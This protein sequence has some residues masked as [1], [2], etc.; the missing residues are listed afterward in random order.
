MEPLTIFGLAVNIIQ[1]VDFS[2]RLLREAHELHHSST[3]QTAEHVELHQISASLSQM[4]DSLAYTQSDQRSRLTLVEH[5]ITENAASAKAVAEDL[6]AVVKKLKIND[7]SK[8]RR[9][10][11]FRQALA[12]LWNKDEIDRLQK[13]LGELRN[14][15]SANMI[16]HISLVQRE[17]VKDLN[18]LRRECEQINVTRTDTVKLLLQ[19]I[20]KLSLN[21][22]TKKHLEELEKVLGEI[23]NSQLKIGRE[24]MILRSLR[25]KEMLDRYHAI[26]KAHTNTFS[27]IFKPSSFPACDARSKITFKEWLSS[28]TGIYWISGK[29]GSGKSTLMKYLY[30]CEET[31]EYLRNWA[32]GGKLIVSASYFWI[33]G[34]EMQRSLRGLLQHLLFQV[35]RVCPD[36]I[37]LLFSERFSEDR[38]EDWSDDLSEDDEDESG[39]TDVWDISRLQTTFERLNRTTDNTKICFFIDGLDEYS[40]DGGDHLDLINLIRRL[41]EVSNVKLC[42]SSRRWTCFED[43]FGQDSRHKLYLEDLT[44]DDILRFTRDK[45]NEAP[46]YDRLM[47]GQ[48]SD[49]DLVSE[50][51]RK[52]QGVFLWVHLVVK[53]LRRILIDGE[54]DISILQ[55]KLEEIPADLEEFFDKLL[56]SVDEAYKKQM[57]LLFKVAL[58]APEPLSLAIYWFLDS[59]KPYQTCQYPLGVNIL[60]IEDR[61][62]R[63]LNGRYKGLLEAYGAPGGK[64]VA[65][66]HR[67]VH[68]YLKKPDIQSRFLQTNLNI[69]WEACRAI[70]AAE[71]FSAEQTPF[72]KATFGPQVS[73]DS[74]RWLLD[75]GADPNRSTSEGTIFW[76]FLN[77]YGKDSTRDDEFLSMLLISGADFHK[78]AITSPAARNL[79]AI[80]NFCEPLSRLIAEDWKNYLTKLLHLWTKLLKEG[81]GIDPNHTTSSHSSWEVW[82]WYI[83]QW[84]TDHGLFEDICV[85]VMELSLECDANPHARVKFANDRVRRCNYTVTKIMN[86][87][88]TVESMDKLRIILDEAKQRWQEKYPKTLE[89]ARGSRKGKQER[90][91]GNSRN[92]PRCKK[93]R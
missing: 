14:S 38:I 82:L 54:D 10:R 49:F 56:G 4:C 81:R 80:P 88:F 63:R 31:R 90:D 33:A 43:T 92:Y 8:R 72:V 47:Q 86:T 55:Q 51:T 53:N 39:S 2:T 66:L 89:H 34:T 70:V 93:R 50:I 57:A 61:M 64:T 28:G 37:H 27:W 13:R 69:G 79:P 58:L 73:Y 30:G 74:L 22:F 84:Q 46:Q 29:P 6:I 19:E 44:R 41:S 15:L 1:V 20:T 7:E 26:P 24:Q 67:T 32:V 85:R 65:F 52:A 12:T 11:D 77:D 78:A 75:N 23:R 62:N 68:D 40:G 21:A 17:I 9:W 91:Q 76:I 48:Q 18:A 36:L 16:T 3:G 71:P 59:K 42:V 25:F 87:F 5:Q 35:L 45:L 60:F 83:I